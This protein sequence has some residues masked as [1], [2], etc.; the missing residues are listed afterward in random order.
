MKTN[1]YLGD[2]SR[3]LRDYT[4]VDKRKIFR[5]DLGEK[6]LSS[7]AQ[8]L[9]DEIIK[10]TNI[11]INNAGKIEDRYVYDFIRE[12]DEI[13][14][15]LI[16]WSGNSDSDFVRSRQTYIES[17]NQRGKSMFD[18]WTYIN[19]SIID[20]S[21]I[22]E[23]IQKD[24]EIKLE[25]EKQIEGAK[26]TIESIKEEA[27]KEVRLQASEIKKSA[28]KT[29]R[30]ISVKEAQEQ[31]NKA[32]TKFRINIFIRSII[33]LG[34][35]VIFY[36]SAKEFYNYTFFNDAMLKNMND[37]GEKFIDILRWNSIYHT[38]IRV[39]ILA[40]IGTVI[41]FCFKMLRANLHMF[42]HN[43]HRQRVANSLEA[44]VN[45]ALTDDQSDKILEKLVEAVVS[46]GQS[47]LIQNEDDSIHASK[48]TIDS[49]SKT[50]TSK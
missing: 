15:N 1:S 9:F 23:N 21:G 25:A 38:L 27:L 43:L 50:L 10:K 29:A 22:L 47:G 28:Q 6:G 4:D 42:Q 11:I 8:P 26:E 40:V 31:F 44:F 39:S 41:A 33:T 19:I 35:F 16:S 14:K 3:L 24:S 49:I 7:E 2:L 34:V 45:A 18:K 36:F 5:E 37:Y 12:A 48:L 13:L 20:E 17:L 30:Q 46:F 32:C